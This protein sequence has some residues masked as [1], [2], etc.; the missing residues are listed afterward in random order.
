MAIQLLDRRSEYGPADNLLLYGMTGSGKSTQL[1]ELIKAMATVECP[2]RV[3]LTDRGGV[4]IY[5]PL[6]VKGLCQIEAYDGVSDRFIWIDNAVQGKVFREGK[7]ITTDL[8]KICLI[9]YDSLSGSGGLVLNALGHQAAAGNNVGGEPAPGL[10]IQAEGQTIMVP[11]GSRTHYLVGQRYIQEKIWQSQGLDC[12]VVWTA[13]EDI[14]PLDKKSADG[15]KTVETAAGLG[16]R[17]IIGPMVVGSALTR[18]LPKDFVYTFRLS[19]TV[20]ETTKTHVMYTGRHKEGQLEGLANSRTA[21]GSKLAL[22]VETNL[23]SVLTQIR[24]ELH[25]N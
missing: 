25:G 14:V 22:K 10:K 11:S 6:A 16:I 2:G 24:K 8:K 23:V 1:A 9:G 3:Y 12:P 21:L 13:H 19:Q 15:E 17:G 5:K 4:S 7:W 18:E 20:T